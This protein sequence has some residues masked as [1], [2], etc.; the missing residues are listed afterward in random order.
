M[1]GFFDRFLPD[2]T[3]EKEC[4]FQ[5]NEPRG[6]VAVS[7]AIMA[8]GFI[9]VPTLI[10]IA[11]GSIPFTTDVF[12][13]S[14]FLEV[15][16]AINY[17]PTSSLMTYVIYFMFSLLA[18]MLM[19]KPS[20][21]LVLAPIFIGVLALVFFFLAYF[22]LGITVD[23]DVFMFGIGAGLF[24]F[25]VTMLSPS[26]LGAIISTALFSLKKCYVMGKGTVIKK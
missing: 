8:A 16:N 5:C 18:G 11:S 3:R 1:S 24:L 13:Q 6:N 4:L 15:S 10:R 25:L 7:L 12:L 9:I 2:D 17:M 26:L 14:L 20:R 21:S 23:M 19:I 22:I